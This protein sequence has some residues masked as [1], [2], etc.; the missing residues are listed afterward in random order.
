MGAITLWLGTHEAQIFAEEAP[1][2]PPPKMKSEGG[3][4]GTVLETLRLHRQGNSAE[5]IVSLR[6]FAQMC[7]RDSY[8]HDRQGHLCAE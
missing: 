6:G 5:K 3:L 4:T 8:Q 1:P 2:P 7:I